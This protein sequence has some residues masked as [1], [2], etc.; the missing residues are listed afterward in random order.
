MRTT[1][2]LALQK[3]SLNVLLRHHERQAGNGVHNLA[4]LVVENESGAVRAYHGNVLEAAAGGYIDMVRAPRSTGSLLKPLLFEGLMARGAL[5][6]RTLLPDLPMNLSGFVPLNYHRKYDGAVPANE[7]LVRSLNIPAVVSLSKYGVPEFLARLRALGLTTLNKGPEHYGLALAL[8][9]AQGRLSELVGAYMALARAARSINPAIVAPMVFPGA[10]NN[11]R[12]EQNQ[13]PDPASAFLTLEA[14]RE[15]ERPGVEASWRQ[16]ANGR[17]VAWKTGTSQG[18]RDAWAI[19]VTQDHTVGIWVGNTSGEGRADLTGQKAA[20][21]ILFELFDLLP[22]GPWFQPP[23]VLTSTRVCAHSGMR[24]SADC[25]KATEQF[26]SPAAGSAPLCHFCQRTHLHKSKPQRVH[27]GCAA[28][29]DM[30]HVP[31]FVLPPN[32]AH[33]Y[34]QKHPDYKP[35]PS[36]APECTPSMETDGPLELL[37]PD[38]DAKL[39]IPVQLDGK[40]GKTIFMAS[41][42]DRN[43]T[44]HWHL[45][46]RFV[47]TTQDFHHLEISPTPGVHT[48]T[49]V[50]TAGNRAQRRFEVLG[51]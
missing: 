7:A 6:P 34:R 48:V 20:A 45:D 19:G 36:W 32:Q 41:H 4:A 10:H 22:R 9:G 11:D 29:R 3:Q 15:A 43:S 39:R 1:I 30:R 14:L 23:S 26:V 49:V 31:W 50:D 18:H 25:P 27:A 40:R 2:D 46:E 38:N 28:T 17:H 35:L 13:T 24:A 37:R 5:L 44:L 42:R 47:A 51:P 16:H 12:P 8:G 33:L 21:P